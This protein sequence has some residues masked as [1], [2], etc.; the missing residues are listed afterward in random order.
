MNTALLLLPALI[1][2][3]QPEKPAVEAPEAKSDASKAILVDKLQ[4][5]APLL[6]Q[7]SGEGWTGSLKLRRPFR[8]Q[9]QAQARFNGKVILF[10]MVGLAAS[11][12]GAGEGPLHEMVA[13]LSWDPD[14]N[15]Y[16]IR[17][18]R[19][20]GNY[21]EAKVLELTDKKLV[22]ILEPGGSRRIR[23]TI[24]INEQGQWHEIGELSRDSG[25][26]FLA[27]LDLTL[28]KKQGQ[29]AP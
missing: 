16:R 7:W 12:D 11:A 22:W 18:V 21:I 9:A 27:Y 4:P 10:D 1:I 2:I 15:S 26:N 8:M 20:D 25:K 14:A 5:L 3:G 28:D 6:G 13:M 17:A 23:H 24:T 19:T 29:P